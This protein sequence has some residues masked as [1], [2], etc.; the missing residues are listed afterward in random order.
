M[1]G[2]WLWGSHGR[3]LALAHAAREL[4]TGDW[5][6]SAGLGPGRRRL[7]LSAAGIVNS[8]PHRLQPHLFLMRLDN[9]IGIWL[10]HL[11]CTRSTALAAQPGCFPDWYVLSLPGT[12]AVLLREAG[13]TIN[14]MWDQDYDKKV[15]GTAS[16]PIAAGDISTFQ[17][18]VFLGEQLNLAL[19]VL[20]CLNYYSIAL[21]AASL[22]LVVTYPLMKRITYWSLLKR[23]QMKQRK[24]QNIEW[25]ISKLSLSGDF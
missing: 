23:R 21:G 7:S 6:P 12:G 3:S 16:H 18:F 5:R 19:G 24:I 2:A 25:K 11:P 8:V 1:L 15:P 13:C 14:D 22:L 4:H 9:P 10:R 20:L 17:S